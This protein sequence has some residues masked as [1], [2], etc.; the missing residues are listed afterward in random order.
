MARFQPAATFQHGADRARLQMPEPGPEEGPAI[1][2]PAASLSKRG[3]PRSGSK[4]GSM[5]SQAGVR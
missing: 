5:R 2:F 4:V 3:L 1:Y